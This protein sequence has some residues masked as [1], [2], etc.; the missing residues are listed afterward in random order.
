MKKLT[1]LL[2]MLLSLNSCIAQ[3]TGFPE[4]EPTKDTIIF[5]RMI[6]GNMYDDNATLYTKHYRKAYAVD[7]QDNFVAGKEYFFRLKVHQ[8]GT[9]VRRA[10]ILYYSLT[11]KQVR[12]DIVKAVGDFQ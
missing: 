1:L 5:S 11:P 3:R 4:V 8:D 2:I 10:Q 7:R 12:K 6:V 9:Q